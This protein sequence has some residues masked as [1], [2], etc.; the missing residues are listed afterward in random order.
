MVNVETDALVGP[1]LAQKARDAGLVYSLAYGDQPALIAELVDWARSAGLEVVSAGKG[2]RYLPEY[3]ESTPDTIWKHYGITPEDAAKGRLNPQMFNSF[4]D[5]TKSSIEMAATSNATGLLPPRDGLLFPPSGV[6][7]LSTALRP[8][9]EGGV[10]VGYSNRHPHPYP[11]L[12]ALTLSLHPHPSPLP[13]PHPSPRPHSGACHED[14][15]RSRRGG[16]HHQIHDG[17]RPHCKWRQ[18]ADDAWGC[19]IDADAVGTRPAPLCNA[20]GTHPA[21]SRAWASA[22]AGH[23]S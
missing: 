14:C 7:D 3:H 20:V 16:H 23:S 10:L 19:Q 13:S 17:Q 5:G 15:P 9:A 2:T 12:S 8:T 1:L 22:W 21:P 11:Q 18:R 4:L 6:D